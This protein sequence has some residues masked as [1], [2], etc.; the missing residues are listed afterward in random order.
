M[1]YSSRYM[2]TFEILFYNAQKN[3][4]NTFLGTS[5]CLKAVQEIWKVMHFCHYE[6]P[7]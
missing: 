3:T 1:I 2:E 7:K 5:V 6:V 4:R